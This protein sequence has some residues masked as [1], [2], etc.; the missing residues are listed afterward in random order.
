[1]KQVVGDNN[2]KK[3]VYSKIII[4][5]LQPAPRPL[6]TAWDDDEFKADKKQEGCQGGACY[7]DGFYAKPNGQ[8]FYK[9]QEDYV[10]SSWKYYEQEK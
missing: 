9:C 6:C 10:C 8:D 3:H 7:Q 1:M 4:N 2:K 5:D